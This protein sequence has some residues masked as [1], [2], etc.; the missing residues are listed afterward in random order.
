MTG[1]C[2]LVICSPGVQSGKSQ[3]VV[4]YSRDREKKWNWKAHYEV[5]WSN[6]TLQYL[7]YHYPTALC[8]VQKKRLKRVQISRG[9]CTPEN[10]L[11]RFACNA[12]ATNWIEVTKK[13]FVCQNEFLFYVF[14]KRNL[15]VKNLNWCVIWTIKRRF[16]PVV[17]I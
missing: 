8:R 12:Q 13:N 17:K 6:I 7:S 4:T 5:K 10:Q 3:G 9:S 1:A 11:D 15:K 16:F 2:P 14:L